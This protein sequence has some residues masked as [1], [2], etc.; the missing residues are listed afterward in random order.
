MFY[1]ND[2]SIKLTRG[3]SAYLTVPIT[4]SE[5]NEYL[6]GSEDKLILSLKKTIRDANYALYKETIGDNTFH[7]TPEDT[8]DLEFREY[9]YDIELRT[10]S[11]DIYTIIPVSTFEILQEV[12]VNG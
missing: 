10:K 6:M 1:I 2:T 5:G 8:K 12:T 11:G 3:D 9:K 7:I 4:T